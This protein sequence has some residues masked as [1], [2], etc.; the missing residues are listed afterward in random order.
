MKIRGN[1]VG[2]P[3][4]QPDWNQT[5][6]TKANYIRNKPSSIGGGGY[7]ESG[8][9]FTPAIDDSGTLSW[10]NDKGLT[11]PDPVN[12]VDKVIDALPVYNGEVGN[13]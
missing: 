2:V 11:N 6:Q 12:L 3:N 1:T 7:G 13:V 8:A 5:D 10:T 4:P 9:T